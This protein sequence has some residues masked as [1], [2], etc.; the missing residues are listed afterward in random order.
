MQ[1][2]DFIEQNQLQTNPPNVG[3]K[4]R[5]SSRQPFTKKEEN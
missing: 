2:I 5:H 3:F 4:K 1:K